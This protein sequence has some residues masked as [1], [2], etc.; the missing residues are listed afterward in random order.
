MRFEL[1]RESVPINLF[2][3]YAP[4]DA[5]PNIQLKE[6]HGKRLGQHMVEHFPLKECLFVL[7]D[8]HSRGPEKGWSGVITAISANPC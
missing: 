8:A 2:V 4:T 5:N 7:I 6:G 1:T 3:A